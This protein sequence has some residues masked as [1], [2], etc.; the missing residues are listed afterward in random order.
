[1]DMHAPAATDSALDRAAPISRQIWDA[2]Y[3][4]KAV[5]GTPIDFTFEDS[6][7]RVARALAEAEAWPAQWEPPFYEAL[8]DF[9]FLPAGRILSGAGAD[10]RVTLFNCFVM[11]IMCRTI[12]STAARRGAMMATMRCDHADIEA[13]PAAG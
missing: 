1:M 5:D 12:L 11:D 8:A 10:L 3:R 2:K 9:K 6:W 4:L 13:T 7:H